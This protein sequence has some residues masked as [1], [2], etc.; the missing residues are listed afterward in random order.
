MAMPIGAFGSAGEG[1]IGE[2]AGRVQMKGK[3]PSGLFSFTTSVVGS[4][5]DSPLIVFAFPFS[6]SLNPA[7]S[8]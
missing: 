4:G 8:S 7:M 3:Y 1:G 6:T 5:V 2:A